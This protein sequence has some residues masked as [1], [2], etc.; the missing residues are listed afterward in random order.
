MAESQNWRNTRDYRYWRVAVI[1]RDGSCK[2]CGSIESRHA[3]HI[4]HAT[5]FKDLRFD[6][7]NGITLC[8]DCHSLLHNKIAGGYRYKCE[9][10]HLDR[11]FFVRNYFELQAS[12]NIID[13]FAGSVVISGETRKVSFNIQ[14]A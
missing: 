8:A 13:T 14:Q 11:L 9:E 3:H 4:K 12:K 2:C 10:K 5:Y 1:R 6:V 7:S